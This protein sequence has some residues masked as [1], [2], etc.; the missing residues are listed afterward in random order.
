MAAVGT[1]SAGLAHEVKNPLSAVL[2]YA[3]L[4][5]RKLDQPEVIKK[6]LETIESETRRCN[7]IIS[8]L[9]QFSRLEKGEFDDLA[10][11]DVVEKSV[12]IVDHQLGLNK[13]QVAM[14]L[15]PDMPKVVGNANQLQQ[16]LMNLAINAQQAMEP[17]GGTVDFATY[18]DDENVYISVS[19][20]GPGIS[21]EVAEKIFQPFF[22]TKAAGQGTGL[23]LSVTYGIIRDHHGDIR[24]EKSDGGG[25]RFVIELPVQLSRELAATGSLT[26]EKAS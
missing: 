8:D 3:Q 4:S 2:G 26:L 20:T 17:D 18:F 21:Q 1:L 22:T 12:G 19:D 9:M 5:M 24:V 6:Y 13:V 14:E 7:E 25:A 16:V 15:T 11:N 23:G 10:I